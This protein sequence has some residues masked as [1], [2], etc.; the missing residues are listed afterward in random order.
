MHFFPRKPKP[1]PY[2]TERCGA[3]FFQG[4]WLPEEADSWEWDFFFS[5]PFVFGEAAGGAA[6]FLMG[7]GSGSR[8]SRGGEGNPKP[9]AQSKGREILNHLCRGKRGNPRS[10]VEKKDA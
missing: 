8:F 7:R 10:W 1:V 3:T 4:K 2:N 6:G 9:V 5:P